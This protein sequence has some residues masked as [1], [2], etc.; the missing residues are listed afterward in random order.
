IALV[1]DLQRAAPSLST[2]TGGLGGPGVIFL[3]IR[4]Q[5]NNDAGSSS[6]SAVATYVD[7]VYY[8][9][10]TSGNFGFLDAAQA[11]ILR[12]PQGTLFGRNTTGG[13]LNITSTQPT[14]EFGGYLRAEAGDYAAVRLEG[15]VT[16]PLQ[17]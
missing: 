16:L 10:P 7:G 14:G 13:A 9:R 12:G 1:S 8:A 15:A 4:G 11:E 2:G 3:A 17:G 6:D 5:V